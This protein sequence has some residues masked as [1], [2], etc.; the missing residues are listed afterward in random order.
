MPEFSDISFSINALHVWATMK[1]VAASLLFRWEMKHRELRYHEMIR[2]F[3]FHLCL[4]PEWGLIKGIAVIPAY[5]IFGT[6]FGTAFFYRFLPIKRD[7]LPKPKCPVCHDTGVVKNGRF[8]RGRKCSCQS[9]TA[10]IEQYHQDMEKW[11]VV[12]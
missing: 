9:S 12:K 3:I 10:W 7:D 1:I 2:R 6:R 11:G 4:N 8:R 5:L